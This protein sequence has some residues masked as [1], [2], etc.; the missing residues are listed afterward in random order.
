MICP[1]CDEEFEREA[2]EEDMSSESAVNDE[3]RGIQKEWCPRCKKVERINL[4]EMGEDYSPLHPDET[5]EEF[6]DHENDKD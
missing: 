4:S 6:H 2:W 1:N 5:P 3:R